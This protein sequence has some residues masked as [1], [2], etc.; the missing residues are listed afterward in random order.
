VKEPVEPDALAPIIKTHATQYRSNAQDVLAFDLDG[1]CV[2]TDADA[3][4]ILMIHV[5]SLA[6]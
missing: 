3:V 4:V 1:H 5:E 2:L 6:R